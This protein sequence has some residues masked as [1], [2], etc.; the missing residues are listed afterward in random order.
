MDPLIKSH[1][2]LIVGALVELDVTSDCDDAQ[3][4][5]RGVVS[6]IRPVSVRGLDFYVLVQPLSG[7]PAWEWYVWDDSTDIRSATGRWLVSF[8]YPDEP[9]EMSEMVFTGSSR[10]EIEEKILFGQDEEGFA[11]LEP[12]SAIIHS[13]EVIS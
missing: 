3:V 5:E 1:P 4:W 11:V 10:C 6:E 13:I 12:E 7:E 9:N 8:T 2:W